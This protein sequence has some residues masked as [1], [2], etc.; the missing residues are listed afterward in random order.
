MNPDV[1]HFPE[2][3]PGFEACRQYV[4]VTAPSFE[5]FCSLQGQGPG[6]PA[7][8]AID[9]RRV[10]PEFDCTLDPLDQARLH[11][12]AEDDR[13]S[14]SLLWLAVVT[15]GDTGATVNLR[16]PIVINPQAMCGVQLLPSVS[17]QPLA[18][19]LTPAKGV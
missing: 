11:L 3:L 12:S 14:A 18:F 17:E 6:A 1:V 7:F 13:N 16:A 10:V 15:A 4:V 8:I 2:G 19:A 5:P 9:P